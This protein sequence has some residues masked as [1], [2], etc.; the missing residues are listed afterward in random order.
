[1]VFKFHQ[2]CVKFC[3]NSVPIFLLHQLYFFINIFTNIFAFLYQIFGFFTLFFFVLVAVQ[4]FAAKTI[5]LET[6]P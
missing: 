2:V 4:T 5:K 1:M 6:W 3:T